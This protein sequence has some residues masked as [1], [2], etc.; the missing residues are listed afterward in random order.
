MLTYYEI[1]ILDT[2]PVT[3][4]ADVLAL[5]ETVKDAILVIKPEHTYKDAIIL[6]VEEMNHAKI[7]IHGTVVNSV[8]LGRSSFKYRTGYS[9]YYS[10]NNNPKKKRKILS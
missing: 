2:P 9:Y 4:V 7:Q 6:A 10:G 3:R 8:D 5:G 1:V